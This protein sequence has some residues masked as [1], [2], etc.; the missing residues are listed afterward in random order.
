MQ[1]DERGHAARCTLKMR[2]GVCCFE[3]HRGHRPPNDINQNEIRQCVRAADG[4]VTM[5]DNF[6][7][8][9]SPIA[10]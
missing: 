4:R 10:D 5:F 9:F 3:R 2:P 6:L 7:A 8:Q 1:L